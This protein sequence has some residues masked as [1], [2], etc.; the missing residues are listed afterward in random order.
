MK[1][2]EPRTEE[3]YAGTEHYV[4]TI[5]DEV[6][7]INFGR[8]VDDIMISSPEG[9]IVC[10]WDTDGFQDDECM[11]IKEHD[12]L[13]E[14]GKVQCSHFYMKSYVPGKSVKVFLTAQRN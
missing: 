5:S 1:I 13:K 14:I 6:T 7:C 10:S 3:M 2:I 9:D 4:L 8:Q 11:L 12:N